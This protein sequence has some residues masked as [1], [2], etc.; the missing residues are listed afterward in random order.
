M[1][2][3]VLP[4]NIHDLPNALTARRQWVAWRFEQRADKWTKVPLNPLTGRRASATDPQSWLRFVEV[5][6]RGRVTDVAGIGFVFAGDDPF[7]GIDLDGC[8]DPL[9][10]IL[11]PWAAEIVADLDSYT[12]CSPSGTGVHVIV[13]G[14]LPE[15]VQGRRSGRIE[16]YASARFFTMTGHRLPDTSATVNDRA[17]ALSALIG[18][19]FS[20]SKRVETTRPAMSD[21]SPSGALADAEVI[22]RAMVARNGNAFAA[23]FVSGETTSTLR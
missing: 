21:S 11:E 2:P 15:N 3:D 12:E 23:L 4:V 10:G 17:D 9:T 14:T 20:T 5:L 18:R 19:V 6:E 16:V 22:R 8:R 1:A 13:K 7:V